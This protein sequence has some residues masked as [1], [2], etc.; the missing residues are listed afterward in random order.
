MA[1]C[2]TMYQC[3]NFLARVDGVISL[4]QHPDDP[5]KNRLCIRIGEMAALVEY[6]CTRELDFQQIVL[7]P[8][9]RTLEAQLEKE[10]Q[11]ENNGK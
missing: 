4:T 8:I 5:T 9:C 1:S 2:A 6:D 10:A 7:S 11:E 3:F